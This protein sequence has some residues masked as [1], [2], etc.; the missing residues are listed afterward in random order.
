M[1]R[2]MFVDISD[3]VMQESKNWSPQVGDEAYVVGRDNNGDLEVTKV[4]VV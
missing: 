3:L 1:V 4:Y 2:V